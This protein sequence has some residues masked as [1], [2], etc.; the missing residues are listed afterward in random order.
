MLQIFEGKHADFQFSYS[1]WPETT[2][3]LPRI[4][5]KVSKL[6][7][8]LKWDNNFELRQTANMDETPFFMNIHNTKKIAKIGSNEVNIKT[9]G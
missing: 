9:N 4:N 7:E 8:D 5:Q 3:I 2:R 1:Y 6:N